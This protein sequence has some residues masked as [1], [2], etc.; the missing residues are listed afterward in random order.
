M[1][2][3]LGEDAMSM[4]EMTTKDAEQYINLVSKP[5]VEFETTDSTV[6]SSVM[7]NCYQ[8]PLNGTAKCFV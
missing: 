5:V 1:E 3:T 2:S 4:A 8:T 6:G 7:G